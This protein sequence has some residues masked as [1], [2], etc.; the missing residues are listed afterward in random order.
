MYQQVE[1]DTALTNAIDWSNI[2]KIDNQ[3]E[4]HN[5]FIEKLKDERR[6]LLIKDKE[7]QVVRDSFKIKEEI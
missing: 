4:N 6:L 1:R 2:S 3:K 7:L 5:S